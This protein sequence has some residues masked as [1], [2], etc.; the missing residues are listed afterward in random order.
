MGNG[1]D[2]EQTPV[3]LEAD[4][5]QRGQVDEFLADAEVACVVDGVSVR[6]ARPSL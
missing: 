2:V 4:L 1:L 5:P 6:R 3:G